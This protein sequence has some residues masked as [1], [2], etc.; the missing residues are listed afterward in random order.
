M[1]ETLRPAI[2]SLAAFTL[3][4][5]FVYPLAMDGIA[6]LVFPHQATGSLIRD[7]GGKVVG[8]ELIG[9]PFDNPAYFWSRPTAE[10]NYDASNSSGTN[11]GASGFV[12]DKGHLGAN[13]VLVKNARDRIDALRAADPGNTAPVP[14][15]L[16]TASGSGLD[17]HIS[18]A[19]ALYQVGRVARARGQAPDGVRRVVE[20]HI[21]DRTL[22]LLGEPRVN[23]VVL[24]RALDAQFGPATPNG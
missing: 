13:P 18:P 4:C 14:V 20:A 24:N 15:D 12:D 23:V 21:E 8:S 9:Q 5:G 10:A 11:Q 16:V 22:G 1:K 7:R 6:A 17:P 2:V 3:L 19:A